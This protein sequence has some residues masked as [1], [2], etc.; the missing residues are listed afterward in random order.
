MA[1][2]SGINV[3]ARH[4]TVTVY[5]NEPTVTVYRHAPTVTVWQ[6]P[7]QAQAE[8][9]IPHAT[10]AI[11]AE[12]GQVQDESIAKHSLVRRSTYPMLFL[13]DD[14]LRTSATLSHIL[15]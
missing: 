12:P 6:Y 4:H 1:S 13:V 8:V 11:M 3:A 5:K 10:G 15:T 7:T 14:P 9:L 2:N